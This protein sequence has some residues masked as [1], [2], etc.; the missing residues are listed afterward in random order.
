M[1]LS[2]IF[3]FRNEEQ[4]LKPL[5]DRTE[6]AV[7]ALSAI[8]F[9]YEMIFVNDDSTDRSL[10]LL[11]EERRRNPRIK[12]ITTSRPFG[13]SECV[14]AGM[15]ACRGDLIVY[16]DADLQDPP[17]LIPTLVETWK[18]SPGAE[19]V[20]TTRRSR[21]GET[22]RKLW[23]TRFGY[24]LLG[25]MSTIP[26]VPNSGDFKLLTR[27]ALNELLTLKERKPFLR[28]MISWIGFKQVQVFYDREAR[29]GGDTHFPVLSRKVI[30]NFLDS[31]LIS[32]SD[33]PLKFLLMMGSLVVTG[34]FLFVI[35]V[36]V[37]KMI[38][39]AIPGWSAIM[40][41][42]LF[43][44]GCQI[45]MLGIVG[46]YVHAIFLE[47]KGRPHYIVKDAIGFEF[48]SSLRTRP[49]ELTN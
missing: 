20:Y 17:E 8:G 39:W 21:A 47:C 33:I 35:W 14:L 1:L 9:D 49:P 26:I 4:N 5:I 12:V 24:W 13:V 40:A 2:I 11:K 37:Q 27:R 3:S 6:A 34:S 43:L 32:F 38:G 46:L 18:N 19:I 22:K 48:E 41:T 44:G 7:S 25:A 10:L 28:G 36:F 23:I 42:V 29:F 15:Q 16:L 45:L 31:A 30:G